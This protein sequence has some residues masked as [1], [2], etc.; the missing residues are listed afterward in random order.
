MEIIDSLIQLCWTL[1]NWSALWLK[2]KASER[3]NVTAGVHSGSVLVLLR[4]AGSESN[5][6]II[7]VENELASWSI[8]FVE[9]ELSRTG[10]IGTTR[11]HWLIT[12]LIVQLLVFVFI[13]VPF[14]RPVCVLFWL[15][16]W[17]KHNHILSLSE[18]HKT[19]FFVVVDK[20][21]AL[22][23]CQSV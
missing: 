21:A 9:S 5:I 13:K 11:S 7:S 19:D 22:H 10:S 18:N 15:I 12:V 17:H 16:V 14:Y 20:L 1:L 3:Q 2:I 8:T 6:C 23:T 4:L